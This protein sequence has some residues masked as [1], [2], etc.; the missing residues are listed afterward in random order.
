[1]LAMTTT[2]SGNLP[3][4]LVLNV[5]LA[6]TAWRGNMPV[7]FYFTSAV[8]NLFPMIRMKRFF[9]W[10]NRP[11]TLRSARLLL[12]GFSAAWVTVGLVRMR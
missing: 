1:M 11:G 5:V 6:V 9:W 8:F 2:D 12:A 4:F 3:L 10:W 7:G